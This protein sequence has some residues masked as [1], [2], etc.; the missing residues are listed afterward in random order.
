MTEQ[1]QIW[2]MERMGEWQHILDSS[3]IG[4]SYVGQSHMGQEIQV[5]DLIRLL[6]SG[7]VF[8]CLQLLFT[9]VKAQVCFSMQGQKGFLEGLLMLGILSSLLHLVIQAFGKGKAGELSHYFYMLLLGG[10]LLRVFS[11]CYEMA[12]GTLEEISTFVSLLGPSYLLSVS[13]ADGL[14]SGI[15]GRLILIFVL[16]M[17]EKVY[18]LVMLPI[19]KGYLL[20][21]FMNALWQGNRFDALL[22][23]LGKMLNLLWKASLG[24]VTGSGVLQTVLSKA[25]GSAQNRFLSSAAGMI[26]GVGDLSEGM[27]QITLSSAGIIKNAMGIL[28]ILLLLFVCVTPMVTL[29]S[30]MFTVRVA[31][32]YMGMLGNRKMVEVLK[33]MGDIQGWL[34]KITGTG[35]LLF[36]IS[37]AVTCGFD[38]R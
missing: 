19:T 1:D 38:G 5:G 36:I 33:W 30:Y 26:P 28:F 18:V 17:I 10:M 32:A 24:I 31:G 12:H 8:G 2:L 25:T 14:V 37:I 22:E 15:G 3:Y 29:F 21:L 34:C 9:S 35:V 7:D 6:L 4:Q 11:G 16:Q 13:A 23:L 27:I 20:I